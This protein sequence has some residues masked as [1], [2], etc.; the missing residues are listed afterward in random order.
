MGL[1]DN[2]EL[3]NVSLEQVYAYTKSVVEP[4]ADTVFISC[5]G[6]RTIGAIEALEA[7]LG[8]SVITSNQATF[9]D[10]LC[11][12]KVHDVQPGFGSLFDQFG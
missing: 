11:I 9:W 8:V 5:T 2:L 7:D 6:L 12:A 4:Q 3:N 10:A 1:T